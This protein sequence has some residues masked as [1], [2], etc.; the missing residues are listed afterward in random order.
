MPGF[1]DAKTTS[2]KTD[3]F[4]RL[5]RPMQAWLLALLCFAVSAGTLLLGLH[6]M[7]AGEPLTNMAGRSDWSDAFLMSAGAFALGACLSAVA[8]GWIK[9]PRPEGSKTQ[10]K[11]RNK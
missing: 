11:T 9:S 4:D 7:R 5:S 1:E 3:W 8:M 6:G 10:P 2:A